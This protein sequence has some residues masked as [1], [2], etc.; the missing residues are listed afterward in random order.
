[1]DSKVQDPTPEQKEQIEQFKKELDNAFSS[2]VLNSGVLKKYF[3]LEKHKQVTILL[4]FSSPQDA[5]EAAQKLTTSAKKRLQFKQKD[6][7]NFVSSSCTHFLMQGIEIIKVAKRA[8]EAEH[9][10]GEGL[11]RI[12]AHEMG[13][14]WLFEI[15]YNSNGDCHMWSL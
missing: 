8:F 5:L 11:N 6:I 14:A 12:V 7:E 10:F 2:D 15:D 9:P 3:E 13:I 4:K 1:M